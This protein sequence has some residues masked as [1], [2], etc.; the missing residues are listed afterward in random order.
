MHFILK[1]CSNF[2]RTM[3]RIGYD[4]NLWFKDNMCK[5]HPYPALTYPQQWLA[6]QQTRETVSC[7][8]H[9]G[10]FVLFIGPPHACLDHLASQ[11]P[12]FRS[13]ILETLPTST[14]AFQVGWRDKGDSLRAHNIGLFSLREVLGSNAENIAQK[15][16]EESKK[17][18]KLWHQDSVNSNKFF[19][20][21]CPE[22][23]F[24]KNEFL[25]KLRYAL[26]ETF[27]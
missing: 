27:L 3:D 15:N 8:M 20:R 25:K 14:R 1:K 4:V 13:P 16:C 7:R 11:A 2:D 19:Q 6:G 18:M 22:K 9:R 10:V 17:E 26:T 12:R 24:N 5:P 23:L 21:H